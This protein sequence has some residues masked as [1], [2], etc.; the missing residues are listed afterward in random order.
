ME[1]TNLLDRQ[2]DLIVYNEGFISKL[3]NGYNNIS[4]HMAVNN[5]NEQL[6]A[7]QLNVVKLKNKLNG[8]NKAFQTVRKYGTN[9]ANVQPLEQELHN[10]N[11]YISYLEQ[12]TNK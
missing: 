9:Q 10:I 1:L 7:M 8:L 11:N 2:K 12:A 3:R 6:K 4:Y 5:Y